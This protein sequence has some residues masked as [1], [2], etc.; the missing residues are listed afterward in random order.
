MTEFFE[1]GIVN[2][3]HFPSHLFDTPD[4]QALPLFNDLDELARL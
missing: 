1:L 3:A 4:F 2:E